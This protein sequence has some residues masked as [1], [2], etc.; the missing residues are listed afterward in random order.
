MS[1]KGDFLSQSNG[2]VLSAEKRARL[3]MYLCVSFLDTPN[4]VLTAE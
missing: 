3:S 4:W 2:T 1:D